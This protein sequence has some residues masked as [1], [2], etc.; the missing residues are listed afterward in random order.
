M[1]NKTKHRHVSIHTEQVHQT[2]SSTAK[3]NES[4]C[5]KKQR[6]GRKHAEGSDPGSLRDP[7]F[8]FESTVT[9]D[10]FL[11]TVPKVISKKHNS[12]QNTH[13]VISSPVIYVVPPFLPILVTFVSQK[14]LTFLCCK[15]R[16]LFLNSLKSS[17]TPCSAISWLLSFYYLPIIATV[18][19]CLVYLFQLACCL[20]I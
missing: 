2:G 4:L 5:K 13:S 15:F 20:S 3:H 16:Q 1:K 12:T 8:S 7:Q 19:I 6:A 18:G 17:G 11:H 14:M 10:T 9:R